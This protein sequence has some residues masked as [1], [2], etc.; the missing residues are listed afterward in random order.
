MSQSEDLNKLYM[1]YSTHEI[2]DE[3]LIRFNTINCLYYYHGRGV[4][5]SNK[6]RK[7]S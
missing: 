1:F 2:N 7:V 3:S 5:K 6:A 4:F